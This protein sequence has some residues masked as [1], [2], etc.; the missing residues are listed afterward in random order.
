M[1]G[2]SGSGCKTSEH[3]KLTGYSNLQRWKHP[4]GFQRFRWTFSAAWCRSNARADNSFCQSRSAQGRP[5]KLILKR[6]MSNPLYRSRVLDEDENQQKMLV[7][8]DIFGDHKIQV[9]KMAKKYAHPDANAPAAWIL[10]DF[11]DPIGPDDHDELHGFVI[12]WLDLNEESCKMGK[13]LLGAL[14]FVPVLKWFFSD[15]RLLGR[16]KVAGLWW[17]PE[18][19]QGENWWIAIGTG[20]YVSICFSND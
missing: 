6:K 13:S 4:H 1:V 10:M 15:V 7:L 17:K 20:Q 5:K 19:F 18:F 14:C 8:V 11:H 12:G 2:R 9:T 16:L 3:F